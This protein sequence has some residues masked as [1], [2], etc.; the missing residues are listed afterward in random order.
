MEKVLQNYEQLLNDDKTSKKEIN[1]LNQKN[2][3]LSN[4]LQKEQEKNVHLNAQLI[5]LNNN[6]KGITDFDNL[7]KEIED[8]YKKSKDE[9]ECSNNNEDNSIIDKLKE[10]IKTCLVFEKLYNEE[11]IKYNDL[12]QKYKIQSYEIEELKTQIKNLEMDTTNN[13]NINEELMNKK[14]EIIKLNEQINAKNKEIKEKEDKIKEINEQNKKKISDLEKNIEENKNQIFKE[15]QSSEL[16]K[17][18]LEKNIDQIKESLKDRNIQNDMNESFKELYDFIDNFINSLNKPLVPDGIKCEKCF[19]E[20]IKGYRYKC[21]VC[22]DYN[23]CEKCEEKNEISK[24]HPHYFIKIKNEFKEKNNIIVNDIM[25]NNSNLINNNN[26]NDLKEIYK[27][28]EDK[29]DYSGDKAKKYLAKKNRLGQLYD[30]LIN[31][32]IDNYPNENRKYIE[33]LKKLSLDELNEDEKILNVN[34]ITE[35]ESIYYSITCKNTDKMNKI[36]KMFYLKYPEYKNFSNKFTFKGKE[37]KKTKTLEENNISDNDN[38]TI[39]SF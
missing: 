5:K 1:N 34:L 37:I 7:Q 18:E 4:K 30:E 14:N 13:K 20:P 35:D 39:K 22:K 32:L 28:N 16:A 29:D 10:K 12:Y 19:V 8:N 6:I 26:I 33:L 27:T 31:E 15:K 17:K 36:I 2:S 21:S 24:E 23:L 25:K 9:F 3:E 38:I 11:K